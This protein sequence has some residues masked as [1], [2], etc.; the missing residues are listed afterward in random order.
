[1]CHGQTS[2]VSCVPVWPTS[3][4][5]TIK[6]DHA[7][8]SYSW[9][10]QMMII[11]ISGSLVVVVGWQEVDKVPRH[12]DVTY[13]IPCWRTVPYALPH[14]PRC[15]H[16]LFVSSYGGP[17]LATL[18]CSFSPKSTLV[19]PYKILWSSGVCFWTQFNHILQLNDKILH[20]LDHLNCR[21]ITNKHRAHKCDVYYVCRW[22]H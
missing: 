16:L 20:M 10:H 19:P 4:C 13:K 1:M 3:Y 2:T 15:S 6:V 18:A 21:Q 22:I 11:F 8:F 9:P 5:T 14:C 17:L 7:D 12:K